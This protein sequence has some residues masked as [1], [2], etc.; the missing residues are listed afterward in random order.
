[1]DCLAAFNK[2]E[3]LRAIFI[4]GAEVK[5]LAANLTMSARRFPGLACARKTALRMPIGT[6]IRVAL[7]NSRLVQLLAAAGYEGL[8][9]VEIYF[10][11][12]DYDSNEDQAVFCYS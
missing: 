8:L 9:A 11:H 1:M 5:T 4:G 12:P 2:G 10:L 7:D 6:L 3:R